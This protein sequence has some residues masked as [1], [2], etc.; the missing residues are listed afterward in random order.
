MNRH[1]RGLSP[2]VEAVILI[3]LVMTL[4]ATMIA[5]HRLWQSR[6]DL[7]ETASA[8][9]RAASL[10]AN[11]QE[12]LARVH[13][14]V[15]ANPVECPSPTVSADLADFQASGPGTVS[16]TLVCRVPLGDLAVPGMPGS[17]QVVG[18]GSAPL[19]TFGERGR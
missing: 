15:A 8:A 9:A 10:A 6:A 19:D 1:E 18:R 2:A 12:A 3:P 11:A 14:V 16:V 4:L 17:I 7:T 5:G 13:A